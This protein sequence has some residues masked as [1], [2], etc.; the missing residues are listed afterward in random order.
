MARYRLTASPHDLAEADRLLERALDAAPWPAG[1][2]AVA[3]GGRA[4]GAR[5]RRPPKRRSPGS[6]PRPCPP[7]APSRLEA[8]SI[9]CEIAF[10]RGRLA[11]ARAAVRRRRRPRPARCAARTSPPRAAIPAE[12][13]A[14]VEAL[15]RRPGLPPATAAP[16]WRSSA[17]RSRWRKAT[18]SVGP[19]GAGRRA[20]LSRLLAERG[21][22]GPAIRARGRPREARRRYRRAR[23][24][25]RQSR[26]VGC[27]GRAGRGGRAT[28][29]KRAT[30]CRAGAAWDARS[31]LLP[32]HLCRPLRPSTCCST[33]IAR[34]GAGA[35]GAPTIAAARISTAD[36]PLCLRAA[37]ATAQPARALEVV[38]EAERQGFLTA[39]LKLA[40]AIALAALGRADRGRQALAEARRAQSAD[41]AARA[42]GSSPSPGLSRAPGR[43]SAR[44]CRG[45]ARTGS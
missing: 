25:D 5:P 6:T 9:R 31:A 3:G 22:R 23:R 13:R 44:W 36:R 42:S 38:R 29:P 39:D 11:E 27:A 35:G 8:R 16:R 2:S 37:G 19:M 4:D 33:A 10:E 43:R 12:R 14:I 34:R 28:K 20:G 17:P 15:L 26:R 18:G 24:A 30:G 1:P 21:V 41:R 7:G 32:L 40:E 45:T